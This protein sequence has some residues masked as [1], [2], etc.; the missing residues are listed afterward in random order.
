MKCI[1]SWVCLLQIGM[2]R[3]WGCVCGC[4][5]L[6]SVRQAY[7]TGESGQWRAVEWGDRPPK[8]YEVPQHFY[9]NAPVSL[10]PVLYQCPN[11]HEETC[12]HS[13]WRETICLY[14]L[15]L[16]MQHKRK[17]KEAHSNSYW[18]ETI[19]LSTLPL[20]FLPN[21]LIEV[22]PFSSSELMLSALLSLP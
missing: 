2:E 4:L 10:L 13:H 3:K 5:G 17:S 8:R 7:S 9:Q 22:S 12:A 11:A 6:P 20:P 15:L 21:R 19:L 18:G 16:H 1:D 14:I